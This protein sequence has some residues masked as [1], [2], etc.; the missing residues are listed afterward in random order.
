[1]LTKILVPLD[2]SEL[3]DRIL[4]FVRRL[5]QRQS[6]ELVVLRVLRHVDPH[7]F[8]AAKHEFHDALAHLFELE[9]R[10]RSEGTQVTSIV[11]QGADAAEQILK[12]ATLTQPS[13]LAIST[14]GRGGKLASLRGGVAERLVRECP[15]PLF[16]GNSNSLPLDPGK[17][18]AKILV[19]LDGSQTSAGILSAVQPLALN[20][21]SEVIL[22]TADPTGTLGRDVEATLAPYQARLHDAGIKRVK[23]VSAIGD[24]A[25]Q[26]LDAVSREGADLLAM[27]SHSRPDPQGRLFGSVA[28]QVVSRCTSPLLLQR[29]PKPA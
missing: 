5:P 18:F 10:L 11:T 2:G 27:T 9:A 1:M 20:H 3:S 21:D 17:G 25:T 7:E 13:L 12:V 29:I 22:F 15:V 16:L 23:I 26:I 6:L 14:H 4:S 24:E 28:E 8:S 19:P